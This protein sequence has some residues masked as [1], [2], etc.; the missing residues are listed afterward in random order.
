MRNFGSDVDRMMKERGLVLQL[1]PMSQNKKVAW[2]EDPKAPEGSQQKYTCEGLTLPMAI[3]G[4]KRSIDENG[5]YIATG[6]RIGSAVQA[7]FCD[8]WLLSQNHF[9]GRYSE[10]HQIILE[11]LESPARIK[12]GLLSYGSTLSEAYE[13]M[14]A[15]LKNLRR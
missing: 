12:T 3:K 15:A 5:K 4:L 14:N 10:D 9:E 2:L 6:T 11:A 13:N 8:W 1:V 7:D